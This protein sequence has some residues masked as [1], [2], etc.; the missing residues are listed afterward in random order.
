MEYEGVRVELTEPVAHV[1]IDCPPVNA[2]SRPVRRSLW[3]A[4]DAVAAAPSVRA[5]VLSGAGRSFPVGAA[6]E[7]FGKPLGTPGLSD[8]CSKIE[9]CGKLVVAALHGS[10]FGGGFEVA[11]ACHWRVALPSTRLA[12]PEVALGL[13]P[14]AGGTQRA[15]R[16]A[17]AD[18]ALRLMLS[19]Q[20]ITVTQ[21]LATAYI[22]RVV[23]QNVVQ[24]AEA[25]ARDHLEQGLA[26][27]RSLQVHDGLADA[28]AFQNNIS[29]YKRAVKDDP[30]PA[31]REIVRAVE[32]AFLLPPEAGMDFETAAFDALD[33]SKEA[34]ALQHLFFAERAAAKPPVGKARRVLQLG[35]AGDGA[36]AV[37][38]A[39]AGLGVGLA[40]AHLAP[41]QEAQDTVGAAIQT[42]LDSA[43][44]ARRISKQDRGHRLDRFVQA[45]DAAV[46]AGCEVVIGCGPDEAKLLAS[47]GAH[48]LPYACLV[49]TRLFDLVD[50]SPL[51]GLSL[52][53]ESDLAE[54]LWSAESLP[55]DV[56]TLMATIRRL[57]RVVVASY[58]VT[59]SYHA[60]RKQQFKL[61]DILRAEGI[62][63]DIIDKT[64]RGLGIQWPRAKG[65]VSARPGFDVARCADVL[66]AG[67]ASTGMQLLRSGAVARAGDIDILACT[68]MGYDRLTGGPMHLAQARGLIK[69]ERDLAEF[70]DRF[71]DIFETD[72]GLDTLIKSGL[73]W[74]AFV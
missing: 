39:M 52:D 65:S 21:P 4:F 51:L 1:I 59:P 29:R 37:A 13:I 49:T 69:L 56:A 18:N 61:N 50:D 46:V 71:S 28:V 60:L 26:P 10:V 40:V 12:F 8:L 27:R 36:A 31:K 72:V 73:G 33:A 45:Q 41:H 35:I 24:A 17:G 66:V 63:P 53:F 30:L 19:G 2:L 47:T 43:V 44:A 25:M 64:A 42:A 6:I 62:A 16:L 5:V 68:A 74:S 22:D 11:L 70:S 54:V 58:E 55:E 15:P 14:G 9:A 67:M 3:T 34:R 38:L 57:G 23:G 20:P 32:A 7:E 48:A